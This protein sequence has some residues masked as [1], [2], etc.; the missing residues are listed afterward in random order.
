MKKM[1]LAI[2]LMLFLTVFLLVPTYSSNKTINRIIMFPGETRICWLQAE[3]P[4]NYEVNCMAEAS[5]EIVNWIH[6]KK[7]DFGRL[8]PGEVKLLPYAYNL[9]IP[10]KARPGNY[11]L[12]WSYYADGKLFWSGNLT[13]NV[14]RIPIISVAA[15]R[16]YTGGLLVFNPAPYPTYYIA[17]ASGSAAQ[18]VEPKIVEVG[19]VE[20]GGNKTVNDVF[21]IKIPDDI[22]PGEYDLMWSYYENDFLVNKITVKVKINP[23]IIATVA[24][25][26]ELAPE[27]Q[28]LRGLRDKVFAETF[29]GEN[30][31]KV[32]N[33]W[34]YSFSPTLAFYI[35]N[36]PPL[37]TFFR[38]ILYPTIGLAHLS[39]WATDILD[40]NPE[41]AVV[42]AIFTGSFFAGIIYFSIPVVG[43]TNRLLRKIDWKKIKKLFKILFGLWVGSLIL[44][45]IGEMMFI[46]LVL[47]GGSIMFTLLTML[48]SIFPV[49]KFTWG[50][51]RKK[52]AGKG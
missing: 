7:V 26:S 23:C 14:G 34:Y 9:T 51:T 41:L 40:F 52:Y 32:V 44:L 18:W 29:V 50:F 31:V 4:Y 46:S 16:E 45:F 27:V 3:N 35:A 42:T 11:S 38:F 43:L 25:G 49:L 22:Y 24:Y 2:C 10:F 28:F 47:M 39:K 21:T 17:K 15:G 13:V 33:A 5:G 36:K 48:I 30:F 6:P 12:T 37:K 20:A 19:Y 8:K 1:V